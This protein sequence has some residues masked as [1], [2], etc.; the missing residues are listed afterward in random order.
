MPT[1][2]EQNVDGPR[3]SQRIEEHRRAST[4]ILNI[5][6]MVEIMA[7]V[8]EPVSMEEVLVDPSWRATMQVEYDSIVKSDTWELVE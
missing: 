8:K 6:L 5:A 1:S 4:H 7:E 3:R 2:H